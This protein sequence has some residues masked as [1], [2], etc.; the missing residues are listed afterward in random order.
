M[1]AT[2]IPRRLQT[3][4]RAE[5][6]IDSAIGTIVPMAAEDKGR[7]HRTRQP[8]HRGPS[9]RADG[10][11]RLFYGRHDLATDGYRRR[12][13]R[14]ARRAALVANPSVEVRKRRLNIREDGHAHATVRTATSSRER[15]AAAV[16]GPCRLRRS[17]RGAARHGAG[18]G[19]LIRAGARGAHRPGAARRRRRRRL[20]ARATTSPT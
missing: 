1:S 9:R 20:V 18:Q 19:H 3:T 4:F 13:P 14:R 12:N 11:I 16:R 2:W 17:P 10:E 8:D 5:S 7:R 15:G 6:T